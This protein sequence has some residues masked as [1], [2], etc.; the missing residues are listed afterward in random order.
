MNNQSK[1][2]NLKSKILIVGAGPA[3]ASLAIRLAAC[4]FETVLIEREKFPRH[5]LCGEFISPECLEHF[6]ALGVLDEMLAAGGERITETRFYA[7]SGRSVSVPSEWLGNAQGALGLSRAEMDF[8]LLEKARAAGVEVFEETQV[9]GLLF[10]NAEVCGVRVRSKDG[11]TREIPADLTIDAT[12]RANVLGKLVDKIQN[13]KFKIQNKSQIPNPKSQIQNRLV[14][15]KAHLENVHLEKGRCEIYFFRGGYGG[16]SHVENDRANHCFLIRAE[17]VKKYIGQTNSL[18]EEVI[19]ENRRARETMRDATAV[20]D[21]LAVSVDGFGLKDLTPAPRLLAVGD[22]AAFIDP[23]TGSGMLMALE[24]AEILA[25]SIAE[26]RFSPAAAAG[27]Y[28]LKFQQK[29]RK[30]LRVCSLMRRA[31]FV[32]NFAKTVISVLSLSRVAQEILARATRG[33]GVIKKS[34]MKI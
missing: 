31:A 15:F 34:N 5:K 26:N 32:P 10:E 18:V 25:R 11:A 3:G 29:F 8:R 16:L 23:F 17:L 1:I 6:R 9:I 4:G 27:N 22:A 7:P 28:N 14:G 20:I 13:S 19:F 30:R 24:S 33:S 21:W 12:G 2:Q